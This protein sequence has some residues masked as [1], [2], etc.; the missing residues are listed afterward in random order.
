MSDLRWS[1]EQ[2]DRLR[3]CGDPEAD[4]VILDLFARGD[5]VVRAIDMLMRDLVENDDVPATSL[6]AGARAYFLATD[7]P[8][9]TPRASSSAS[10]CSTATAR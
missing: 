9:P 5:D 4:E 7:L 6:P 1:D 3:T 8:G 2:L 10:A